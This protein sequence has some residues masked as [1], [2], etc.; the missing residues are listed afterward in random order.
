M[1][2]P[3]S[4][5]LLGAVRAQGDAVG[6]WIDNNDVENSL[7]FADPLCQTIP[8]YELDLRGLHLPPKLLGPDLVRLQGHNRFDPRHPELMQRD[9]TI[10]Y[11]HVSP[12]NPS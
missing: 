8:L 12:H 10:S 4:R 5:S 3:P 7:E 11:R 2:K 9:G 1:M 6:G